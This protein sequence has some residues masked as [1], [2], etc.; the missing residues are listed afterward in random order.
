MNLPLI[1]IVGRPNVGKSTLFN[2][3]AGKDRAL[4]QASPGVTRDLHYAEVNFGDTRFV[5][6]DTGGLSTEHT[7]ALTTEVNLQVDLAIDTADAIICVMDGRDG[8]NP[9]DQ[10]VADRLRKIETPVF[11]A[12]NKIDAPSLEHLTFEFYKLG[13]ETIY[14]ISA[15]EKQGVDALFQAV[16]AALPVVAAEEPVDNEDEQRAVRVAFVGTPNVGKS[17]TINRILGEKRL[18]VSEIPGTTRDAIDVPFTLDDKPYVLIDTAGLRRKGK[19]SLHVEKLSAIKALHA[20]GRT[21]IAVVI[22]DSTEPLT[23]QTLRIISYAQERGRGIILALNKIDLSQRER[24]WKARIEHDLDR[25]MAGLEW[26]PTITM[27]A[28]TGEGIDDLFEAIGE[29][30][31]NTLRRLQTGP[32]NRFLEAAVAH[33]GPPSSGGRLVKLYYAAQTS[34]RPPTFVIFTNKPAGIHFAYQRYL[35][36]RLRDTAPFVGAPIRLFFRGRKKKEE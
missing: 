24:G 15:R 33:H 21:D 36:N 34:V 23:D 19:V 7:D 26:I 11:W 9:E 25:R 3:I 32:L 30:R 27:S 20:L 10:D 14:A 28:Q 13:V 6:V 4:V 17:S 31:A 8:L 35:V 2:R 16:I 1:A 18:I 5:L 22:H 29:V 12:V